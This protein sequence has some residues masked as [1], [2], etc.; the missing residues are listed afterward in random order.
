MGN[1]YVVS[2]GCDKNRV[3]GETMIGTLRNAGYS[4]VHDPAEA[5]VIVVNTCGFIQDAVKE[6]ID[7]IL[8]LSEYKTEGNC[9]ALIVVGCMAQRYK[10]EIAESIPEADAIIGVGEYEKIVNI[11]EKL[12][13]A[14]KKHDLQANLTIN[15]LAA[16]SDDI[17]PH[18][19][20]V[21]IAE[22]C[23]NNCTYCTI[24]SIRGPYKSRAME[25]I[26]EECRQLVEAGVKELVLVAQD[27]TLYGTDIYG[28]KKLPEL[29]RKLAETSGVTWIRLMYA[30]PEHI[31]D[32][33][34]DTI[35]EI[36]QICKYID[37]PIQHSSFSVLHLMGR[38]IFDS[39]QLKRLIKK[40]RNRIPGIAIRTTVMLGFPGELSYDYDHL[41]YFVRSTQFERLGAFPYS[42]EEGTPAAEMERQIR[43]VIK[44]KRVR[45]IMELQQE[46]HFEKQKL[47]VG[48]VLP[49]MV[50]SQHENGEYVGRTQWDAYE[51]D[52]I[53][54]F[55][56]EEK[57][58]QGE[59]C[60]VLILG[61][62]EYDLRGRH[63][64]S[65]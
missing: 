28:K 7:F 41:C 16:R 56:S 5:Q 36:P 17:I 63:E 40:M 55:T 6:S 2:L 35:A 49:V 62:D 53:V 44:R 4:V 27:T 57:L 21:K 14:T 18:I 1:I 3:D 51:V 13:G 11:V 26:L 64:S 46:I 20:Y 33:L 19:A 61:S 58:E 60:Q 31:T 38:G 34:I 45:R 25:D 23:D 54:T 15:R 50:D 37:M 65:K 12:I 47:H 48:K 42:Q 39:K 59:V 9:A 10:T 29:L 8:E 43:E 22:G 30:Y 52:T 32:E 24:P